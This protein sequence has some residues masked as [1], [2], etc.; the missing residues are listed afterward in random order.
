MKLLAKS[1]AGHTNTMF[2]GNEHKPWLGKKTLGPRSIDASQRFSA[3][4]DTP[5]R[6]PFMM[7]FWH[8]FLVCQ[9]KI[10]ELAVSSYSALRQV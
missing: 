9:R 10:D 6:R 7:A 3:V 4:N 5:Y 2:L 8:D 1:L